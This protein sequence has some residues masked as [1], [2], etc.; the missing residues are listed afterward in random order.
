MTDD[1][2][3]RRLA[4]RARRLGWTAA[5]LA[6]QSDDQWERTRIVLGADDASDRVLADVVDLI[7]AWEESER[8]YGMV[9]LTTGGE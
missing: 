4:F 5:D 1:Q 9:D 6:A 8:P 3:V 7:L 2:L